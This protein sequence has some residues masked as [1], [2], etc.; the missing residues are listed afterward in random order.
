MGLC[1]VSY[2]QNLAIE[3]ASG[4]AFIDFIA[5]RAVFIIREAVKPKLVQNPS[6]LLVDRACNIIE[7]VYFMS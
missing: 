1:I 4:Y 5:A 3:A 6:A 2:K 7:S